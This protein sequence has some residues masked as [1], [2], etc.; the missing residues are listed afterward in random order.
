MADAQVVLDLVEPA[1][2]CDLSVQLQ[3]KPV[4]L[5]RHYTSGEISDLYQQFEAFFAEMGGFL[6]FLMPAPQGLQLHFSRATEVVKGQ[7]SD[8][9][10]W[11]DNTLWLHEKDIGSLPDLE[12]SRL[13]YQITVW[14]ED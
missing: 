3:A 14:M 1:N 12:L 2:Q 8:A 9:S 13:P 4:A 5:S 7:L 6:S 10:Y 11:Q